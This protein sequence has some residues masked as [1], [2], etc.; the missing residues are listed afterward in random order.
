MSRRAPLLVA[1]V[2]VILG[3][4]P[5]LLTPGITS[6]FVRPIVLSYVLALV[7]SL[8]VALLVTPTLA[9]LLLGDHGKGRR[10]SPVD[11]WV[12]RGF[13][14]LA[15][16]I[17][18]HPGPVLVA[19][20]LLAVV[21]LAILTQVKSGPVLPTLQDRNMLVRLE[22]APG[23]SLTDMSRITS[24]IAVELRAVPGVESA[25]A[26]V[27]RAISADEVVDVDP[28][29]IWGRLAVSADYSDTLGA[30]KAVVHGYPG[31][32]SS[33]G[34]YAADRVAAVQGSA[35]RRLVVRVYGQDLAILGDTADEVSKVIGTIPGVLDPR[36]EPQVSEPTVEI[37]V[38]LATAQKYGL[39]PG[40][41]RRE[42]STLISGLT[43]GSLYE[44][45]KIFDVVV[46]GGPATRQSVAS[47]RSLLIDTPSGRPVRLG[48][49]AT[50]RVA[51]DP[52]AI[53]HDAVSRSA[54]VTAMVVGRN[55]DDVAA[56]VTQRLRG[57]AMPYEYRAEVLEDALDRQASQRRIVG[58]AIVAGLLIL[59]LL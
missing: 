32:H 54:D 9:V 17:M 20:V 36:T 4:T 41:V 11:R 14:R 19:W 29:E 8:I 49:V 30:V 31:L 25:G 42:A 39:R 53:S 50:V 43:V 22:A 1:A 12:L 33:I 47:L 18:G 15:P 51:P 24:A 3:L 2:V 44:Q 27:G 56:E 5:L 52:V 35:Q 57:M 55:I 21:G 28:A 6:A 40:D 26:H 48:E 16:P 7:T 46:W 10:L 59:L 45:Q 37:E 38:D 13:D 34:T 23:T 58:L